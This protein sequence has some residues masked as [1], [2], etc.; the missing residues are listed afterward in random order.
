MQ[1]YNQ[2]RISDRAATRAALVLGVGM[3]V[4]ANFWFDC[5]VSRID[6]DFYYG[7]PHT[8]CFQSKHEL[9]EWSAVSCIDP[10][11]VDVLAG[12]LFV[13]GVRAALRWR[14]IVI[15]FPDRCLFALA[16]FGLIGLFGYFSRIEN[17]TNYVSTTE[18]CFRSFGWPLPVWTQ[19]FFAGGVR[20]KNSTKRPALWLCA[21]MDFVISRVWVAR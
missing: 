12:I 6:D 9:N 2:S 15:S 11:V 20:R 8:F 17:Y 21:L 3:V 14:L 4:W 10:V 19:E 18:N 1:L 16:A 7:W 5:S 13:F